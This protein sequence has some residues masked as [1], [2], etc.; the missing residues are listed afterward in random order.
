MQGKR[1]R[2]DESFSPA[3][4]DLQDQKVTVDSSNLWTKELERINPNLSFSPEGEMM[5][6]GIVDALA[7]YFLRDS[8]GISV[9]SLH[10][11]L[12]DNNN[13]TNLPRKYYFNI[14]LGKS[15]DLDHLK[16]RMDRLLGVTELR[17]HA[18]KEVD[19]PLNIA[20][21]VELM[22]LNMITTISEGFLMCEN[23]EYL[24]LVA[25]VLI[26][27]SDE[28]MELAGNVSRDIRASKIEAHIIRF[29]I[30]NDEELAISFRPFED[31]WN[32]A[33]EKDILKLAIS[34][35]NGSAQLEELMS[36]IQSHPDRKN[37]KT[38]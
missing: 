38:V 33:Y 30:R 16:E 22:M 23:S 34:A 29:A 32:F 27:L 31:K 6:Q 21:E 24:K 7:Q 20:D 3:K 14:I 9:Y 13:Q 1:E 12:P 19:K 28:V 2:D 11:A 18:Q 4:K 37:A 35:L 36:E 25:K 15:L 10:F 5:M 17:K 26:Y 8:D